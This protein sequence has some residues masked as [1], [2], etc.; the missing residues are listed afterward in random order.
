MASKMDIGKVSSRG[1]IAIPSDMRRELGI[2]D[3]SQILFLL[4]GDTILIKS[5]KAK[6]WDE[7]TEPF[8]TAKLKVKE[9]EMVDFIHKMRKNDPARARHKRATISDILERSL[10]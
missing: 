5:V 7:I 2:S 6:S 9:D 10:K 4:E 1:Q 8:R 3:G